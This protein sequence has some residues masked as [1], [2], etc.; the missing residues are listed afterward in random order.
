MSSTAS[1]PDE[2]HPP[3]SLS[4]LNTGANAPIAN[5]TPSAHFLG[6]PSL[7]TALFLAKNAAAAT[8]PCEVILMAFTKSFGDTPL[9]PKALKTAAFTNIA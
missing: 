3:P 1:F 7:K 5:P 9:A 6:G 4:V 8:I 2:N